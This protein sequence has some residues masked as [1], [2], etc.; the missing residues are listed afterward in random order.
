MNLSKNT[1]I[2]FPQLECKGKKVRGRGKIHTDNMGGP[3]SERM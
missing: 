2:P 1:G 3:P